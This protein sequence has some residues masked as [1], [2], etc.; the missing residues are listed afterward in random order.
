MTGPATEPSRRLWPAFFLMGFVAAGAQVLLLRRLLS[1]LYGN[2]MIVGVALAVWM[3]GTGAGSLMATRVHRGSAMKA[4]GAVTLASV[5]LVPAT[6]MGTY[7]ARTALGVSAGEVLPPGPSFLAC[8]GILLPLTAALGAMFVL[9]TLVETRD[10][11]EPIGKVYLLEAAGAA[12][13]GIA[14][15]FAAWMGLSPFAWSFGL[16][17]GLLG[18]LIASAPRGAAWRSVGFAAVAIVGLLT[19]GPGRV[20]PEKAL[21][22]AWPQSDI[23]A[24]AESRYASLAVVQSEGQRTLFVDALPALTHPNKR[25]AE[26]TIHTALL[27]HPDPRNILVMGG[28]LA[29]AAGE[30]FKYD[31]ETLDYVQ[32][33]PV[34]TSLEREYLAGAAGSQASYD[35]S[36]PFSDPRVSVFNVDGRLFVNEGLGGPYDVVVLDIPNPATVLMNRFYTAEFFLGVKRLLRP[37]G[38]V[39][40]T[41]GSVAN[42][43]SPSL[44]R[45]LA[46][47]AATLRSVFRY[48]GM[49]P[50]GE[51]H[52]VASDMP[53]RLTSDGAELAD[54][55]A[56]RAIETRFMRDYYIGYDLSPGRV[57]RL[58]REVSA[59]YSAHQPGINEDRN[60]VGY[61]YYLIHW[62]RLLGSRL[63]SLMEAPM[64]SSAPFGV[65]AVAV[66]AFALTAA[67]GLG[68]RPVAARAGAVATMG[69]ATLTSQVA[70]LIALQTFRGHLYFA[71]GLVVAAFMVGLSLG[72][73][74]AR[75]RPSAALAAPQA[76]LSWYCVLLAGAFFLPL[77]RLPGDSFTWAAVGAA[78]VGGLVGGVVFQRAAYDN[79][80]SKAPPGGPSGPAILSVGRRDKAGTAAGVLNASDHLGAAFGALVAATLV[81][82]A[83]GL[84]GTAAVAASAAGG[85]ALGLALSR[86]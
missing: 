36:D 6:V 60:P 56:E 37:G 50:L 41:C 38:V 8:F 27:Q 81:L 59:A 70:L 24:T 72:A 43:V 54:R 21:A 23:V 75:R 10:G 49:L 46:C 11:A 19:W 83:L 7:A 3:V 20:L 22:L 73:V 4:L 25:V 53:Y 51:V 31:I 82:P 76:I 84:S 42:Y 52:F 40:L 29:Q 63:A 77:E 74:W 64:G 14:S 61:F 65:P 47:Q 67:P 39:A 69:F 68:R 80:A 15:G 34:I 18:V 44:G 30:A 12:A 28:G 45:L 35:T 13:G 16:C 32:V 17:L 85:S 2:E 66:I 58:S 26:Q 33:D 86:L 78:L 62:Y 48:Q 5:L 9:F 1:L 71:V 79:S 57:E 55:L